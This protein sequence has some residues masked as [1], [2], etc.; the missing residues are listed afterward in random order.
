[1]TVIRLKKPMPPLEVIAQTAHECWHAGIPL[2]RLAE[3]V[4]DVLEGTP[5]EVSI[6]NL[7]QFAQ[8]FMPRYSE[9]KPEEIGFNDVCDILE[10]VEL[11]SRNMN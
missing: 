5:Y 6:D 7:E 1:M 3:C 8:Q 2:S 9:Y 10:C 4:F 11:V